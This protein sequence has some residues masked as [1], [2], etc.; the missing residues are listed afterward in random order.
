MTKEQKTMWKILIG[1]SVAAAVGY[2]LSQTLPDLKRY[3]RMRA[4]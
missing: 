1:G 3:M 2:L 4:M